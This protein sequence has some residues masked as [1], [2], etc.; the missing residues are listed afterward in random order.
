MNVG[1]GGKQPKMRNTI[2]NGQVQLMNYPDD[3]PDES[4]R[5][6]PK[7]M[8]QIL[9]E[10]Q[11]LKPGLKGFCKNKNSTDNQCC[12][13]HILENQPDF[14]AQKGMIQE[15]IEERG[16]KVIFYPKFHPELNFI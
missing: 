6:K 1:P 13:Q 4:L 12:M 3:F 11:L 15:V 7:G 14:L 9:H 16:H 2:F 8:K 10:R 5:G